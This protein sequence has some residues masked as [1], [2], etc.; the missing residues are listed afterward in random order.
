MFPSRSHWCS[1]C[2][3]HYNQRRSWN[4][5]YFAY[6]FQTFT[7]LLNGTLLQTLYIQISY[8]YKKQTAQQTS[9][10]ITK[11]PLQTYWSIDHPFIHY[12]Q[13][14]FMIYSL[15]LMIGNYFALRY[16]LKTSER[17]THFLIITN[18]IPVFNFQ[19]RNTFFF[20]NIF[21]YIFRSNKKTRKILMNFHFSLETVCVN[22][23]IFNHLF[24]ASQYETS[25]VVLLTFL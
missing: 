11:K 4:N 19:I 17:S 20:F 18:S 12:F 16:F 7:C 23:T 9:T 10:T 3:P 5:K 24:V 22:F 21:I 1:L 2:R 13:D 25:F 6:I 8:I 14:W 15:I